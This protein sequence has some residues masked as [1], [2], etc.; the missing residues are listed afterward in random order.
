MF[1]ISQSLISVFQ[2]LFMGRDYPEGYIYF[3]NRAHR[4]FLRNKD[5][6]DP[7]KILELIRFGEYIMKELRALYSLKKYRAMKNRYYQDPPQENPRT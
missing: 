3:R 6:R 7:E 1:E 5:V 2:L 4:A